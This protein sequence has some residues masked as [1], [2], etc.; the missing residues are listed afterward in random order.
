MG[1][2]SAAPRSAGEARGGVWAWARHCGAASETGLAHEVAAAGRAPPVQLSAE[3]SS[4]VHAALNTS[5]AGGR[6][7]LRCS[8]SG[9]NLAQTSQ[10]QGESECE[11]AAARLEAQHTHCSSPTHPPPPPPPP[12]PAAELNSTHTP[13]NT[14]HTLP[15]TH[16]APPFPQPH[17]HTHKCSLWGSR[18]WLHQPRSSAWGTKNSVSLT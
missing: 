13:P 7:R 11:V 18:R 12:P 5:S 2:L 9:Q 1:W 15:T 14:P 6:R 4:R 16:P 3:R 17:P 8:D 10:G